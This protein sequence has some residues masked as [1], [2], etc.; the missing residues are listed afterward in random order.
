ME[1]CGERTYVKTL[2]QLELIV[3]ERLGEYET[4]TTASVLSK[5]FGQSRILT[6]STVRSPVYLR[7]AS[8]KS[9]GRT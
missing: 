9:K 5:C 3:K 2:R 4:R 7:G 1:E 8:G 6:E